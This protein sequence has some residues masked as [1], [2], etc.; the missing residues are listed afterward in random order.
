MDLK[1]IA[2][3]AKAAVDAS[4]ATGCPDA[5]IASQCIF[6]SGSLAHS[7]GNNCFGIKRFAGCFGTQLL[8]TTEWFTQSEQ[9]RFL[10]SGE[11]RTSVLKHPDVAPNARGAREYAVQ[12]IFATFATL[13]D[14]FAKRAALWDKGPY[15]AS[16]AAYKQTGDLKAF[17]FAMAPIYAKDPKYGEEIWGMCQNAALLAALVAARQAVTA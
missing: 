16:A 13:S 3:I 17:V 5:V 10:K 1:I 11:G 9:D 6:E 7:P 4:K 14:C 15:A 2:Q 12:D 8:H